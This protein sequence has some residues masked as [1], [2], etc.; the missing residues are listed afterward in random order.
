VKVFISSV[1]GGYGHFRAAARSA[2]ETLGHQVLMAEDFPALAGT[3]QE[4]CLAGVRDAD[5][6]VLLIG[7]SYGGVQ[8][9]G[10]SASH[11]EYREGRERKPILVFVEAGVAPEANQAEFLQEVQAW[12]TGHF[13]AS[14]SDPAGLSMEVIRALHEHELAQSV[15]PVNE[16]E[17]LAR[18]AALMPQRHGMMGT[19]QI[20]LAIASGP[21]QSVLRPAELDDPALAR[22]S[23]AKGC[24]VLTLSLTPPK[25]PP[26]GC[27]ATRCCSSSSPR[28]SWLTRLGRSV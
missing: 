20:V 8:P 19:P 28:A 9:S 4:A 6:I 2:A 5:V 22:T 18:A 14:Y 12:A 26:S 24:S 21:L 23:S 25:A 1:I 3:P 17:L 27:R 11:E 13:G 16:E 10:L 7:E 15:G